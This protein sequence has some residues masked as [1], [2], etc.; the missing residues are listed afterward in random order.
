MSV[1]LECQNVTMRFQDREVL[2]GVDWTVRTGIVTGLLGGS[3]AGKTTLLRI[4]AGLQQPTAGRILWP[5]REQVRGNRRIVVG[6]VFQNLGLWPHLS[7]RRHVEYVLWSVSRRQRRR[8]AERLLAETRLPPEAWDRRPAQLSGGEA[9]RV[10]LAR[11][12]ALNPDLLLLDEPLSQVDVP[13]RS[14]ML[15]LIRTL[16]A[17][18]KATVIYVTHAWPDAFEL[19]ERIAVL[20]G[21]RIAQEGRTSDLFPCPADGHVASVVR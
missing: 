17:S 14:E 13:L 21:G 10:A 19:C 7:A 9:Q 6:M 11:A 3:G 15:E 5:D 18:R 2:T 4:I 12:L 1:C 16:V 8:Q 20:S